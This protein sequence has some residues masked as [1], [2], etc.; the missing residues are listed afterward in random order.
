M[1]TLEPVAPTRLPS[2]RASG[3]TREELV[4]LALEAGA[5]DA[6]VVGIEDAALDVDRADVLTAFPRARSLLAFAVRM[7][8]A[9]IRSP[10]RSLANLEFHARTRHVDE[11]ARALVAELERRGIA[12]VNPAAGFPMEMERFPG[13]SWVISHKLVAQ[14][15]GLGR[16]GWHR[17]LIHPRF[18]SFVLL[19]TVALAA[20]VEVRSAPLDSNPCFTCKLCVA[21]CPVGAIAADGRFDFAACYTHNYRE[22]MGG[23]G[24]WVEQVAESSGA[25]DYRGRV[26]DA[27][28]AS[29]WQSLA[30]G[31]NYKA[32][33]CIAACPAGED[34]IAPYRA[35]KASFLAE[36]VQPLRDKQESVYVVPGSDAEA[37]VRARLPHK[38]VRRVGTR[39]RPRTISGF[40]RGLDLVFQRSRA[41][42]LAARY[43]FDFTGSEAARA[44]VVIAEQ[45]VEVAQGLEGAAD[46]RVRV[47]GQHWLA[48]VRGERSLLFA[49]LSGRLRV[50]GRFSLFRAFGRCFGG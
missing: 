7:N 48:I 9:P 31:P 10:A 39:F 24:D 43:H 45:R 32:A 26:S 46:V 12:A 47:D 30:F 2:P 42:G 4:R 8:R 37:Y 21:A 36:V 22:F 13:K 38:R 16:I 1:E 5:D 18:G 14:A 28:T 27:E 35:D 34:V 3:I 33:Y 25:A 49:L 15:A 40:L 23:F 44:T 20:E 19:G 29:L 50:R 6:G 17:N 11:V 41:R